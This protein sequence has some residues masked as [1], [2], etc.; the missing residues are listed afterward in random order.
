MGFTLAFALQLR[1]KHGKISVWV[2]IHNHTIMNLLMLESCVHSWDH[3]QCLQLPT[4]LGSQTMFTT[5]YILG[6]PN[7]VYSCV[8]SWDP[9][10]CLQLRTFL[11]S[12]TMFTTAYILGIPNNVYSCVHYWDP[13]QCLQLRTF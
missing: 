10:Q 4:F 5:A 12:Q 11:G 2:A 7:N 1:K 6:I 9:K 8:H 3:K 13:K